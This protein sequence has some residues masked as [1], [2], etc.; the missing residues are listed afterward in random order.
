MHQGNVSATGEHQ[1]QQPPQQQ[2]QAP[3]HQ[4]NTVSAN[5]QSVDDLISSAVQQS[6]QAPAAEP[7]AATP[8]PAPETAE[9]SG[10]KAKRTAKLVYPEQE[11]SPEEKMSSLSGY[12]FTPPT[13]G[14]HYLAPVEGKATG[15]V[16]DSDTVLDAQSH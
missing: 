16:Q 10:K 3:P 1:P 9:K 13:G 14:E 8:T 6:V 2:Q 15:P 12:T 11:T 5:A 4:H 7:L